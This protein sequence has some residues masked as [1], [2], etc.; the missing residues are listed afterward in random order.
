M[1]RRRRRRHTKERNTKKDECYLPPCN[2]F[3]GIWRSLVAFGIVLV[4]FRVVLVAPRTGRCVTVAYESR[5]RWRSPCQHN[6][7]DVLVSSTRRADDA[8]LERRREGLGIY[9]TILL[10][11]LWVTHQTWSLVT[12]HPL[13]IPFFGHTQVELSSPRK[14]ADKTRLD[15]R[16]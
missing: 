6:H 5:V 16:M 14:N 13:S 3:G 8:T 10:L 9:F 11:G 7:N 1:L 15:N 4:A 12:I 2:V